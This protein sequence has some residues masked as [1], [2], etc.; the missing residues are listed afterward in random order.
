MG[1][2]RQARIGDSEME[3]AVKRAEEFEYTD[4]PG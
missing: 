2:G 3:K 1:D 4:A